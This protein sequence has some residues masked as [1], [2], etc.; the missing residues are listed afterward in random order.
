MRSRVLNQPG[1]TKAGELI[2]NGDRQTGGPI[3]VQL[4]DGLGNPVTHFPVNVTFGFGSNPNGAGATLTVGTET[5]NANGIATFDDE[6]PAAEGGDGLEINV[7]NVAAFSDYTIVPK[8]AT[9][10]TEDI[11]GPASAGFDIWEDATK[12]AGAELH[13]PPRRR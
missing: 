5:T 11:T 12:C 1:N 7:A 3:E 13:A 8:G 9:A 4:V 6:T 10:A 2:T